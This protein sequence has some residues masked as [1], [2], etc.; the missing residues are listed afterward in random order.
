MK[1]IRAMSSEKW[2][3][4]RKW[5]N[6][7]RWP[8]KPLESEGPR[9]GDNMQS[10]VSLLSMQQKPVWMQWG[11]YELWGTHYN[12]GPS[13]QHGNQSNQGSTE[14]WL[15]NTAKQ[16]RKTTSNQNTATPLGN[17]LFSPPERKWKCQ[18]AIN[19]ISCWIKMRTVRTFLNHK[20]AF[21]SNC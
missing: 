20:K 5:E 12:R 9:R 14:L 2:W 16:S 15:S 8:R 13:G 21:K 1:G 4:D 17:M 19:S 11:S 6:L 10:E 3:K 7:I 18:C